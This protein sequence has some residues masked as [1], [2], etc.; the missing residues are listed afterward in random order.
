M[1]RVDRDDPGAEPGM[2]RDVRVRGQREERVAGDP[3]GHP[4]AVVAERL[5]SPGEGEGR[6]EVGARIQEEGKGHRYPSS[7]AMPRARSCLL[8]SSPLS[9]R[10]IT[11][12]IPTARAASTL[13]AQS[14]TTN[15]SAAAS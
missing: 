14:S 8:R 1:P 2:R 3:V 12:R 10:W 9:V 7:V 11:P 4:E 15:H 5:T 13:A 6:A